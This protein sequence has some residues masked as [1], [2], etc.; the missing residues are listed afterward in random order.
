MSSEYKYDEQGIF[1][2]V[3]LLVGTSCCVLPLTYSTILGP[4]ESKEKKNVRDPFQKYRPKDLKVQRKSIFRLRYIF[5]ILGWLAIGFLS[6]KIANSRLKLNIWDPYEILGIAKGTS[7]DD[8]RRHYKRLSI[9]FHPDKVRNMVNTTR[10]E[11]EKHYIEITNAY[12]AL[13]DDETRENY[14]LYGTPDVPQHISVGIALPKWISESENSIYIL[15]FYGLVF[16]IVLPYAVGKWWYGSR[17]YTRDHVHVDTVDEWFPKM[18]TSLTLDE[19]LSL[20]AS[21]KELTSLVPNEKNPKEYI[22]KLLFDHL[23]RKKTNNFNTHQI[24]SQSDVV[25]NALLSVATAFGFANP[26][27]N[28]L[29][30]WQHIVQAIPLDAPF[31]LLQL[32]HLL[33]EDVKNL[34]IRNISS[35]PQFLSLSEEQTKDYLPNYSKNQLK[36]MREIANGIPRIS[37]VA[38]KVLV[39]DDEY[40]TVGAIANLI[41]DLKCSYGTEVVPEVSTDGTE[42]ATKK[43][44]EDAEKYHQSKDVVLGDVETLPYAWAP[45]FTQHHKTTWWIYV[46]DPRQNRVIVPPFSITDIPK[47]LRTFRIPFQVPPV[48]G[49]F[50]FQLHIMSNSYVGED[51]ISN[52]T[53][54]VKDTSVLQEQLQEEAVSDLEDNSDIDESANAGKDF[55]DDENIG[56]DEEDESEYDPMDTDTSDGE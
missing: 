11:V 4:S 45:Y 38:A 1:F 28:V 16:G 56:S 52:L 17:T 13:T 36:E 54:I 53:M 10:E 47:T 29:K 40:I 25:L 41:L 35:I 49:T 18:E 2:P 46:V 21:S 8:V 12:R 7:V 44:E 5:L 14:A 15:G 27:D 51:V 55:S 42:T 22:L 24:L 43:D 19:L 33:M 34:S 9:K 37:V 50:S 39:D 30:L 3:F 6:Y 26:V 20:F 32:P 31:P 48:A 23:N